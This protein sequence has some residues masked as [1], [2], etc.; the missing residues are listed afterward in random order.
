MTGN[1]VIIPTE[2]MEG[3]KATAF[4]LRAVADDIEAGKTASVMVC[5]INHNGEVYE[6]RSGTIDPH[7][8]AGI[9][10]SMAMMR[11]GYIAGG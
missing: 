6:I 7:R 5:A 2:V 3:A 1:V 11:L 4:R 8:D 10:M 9:L